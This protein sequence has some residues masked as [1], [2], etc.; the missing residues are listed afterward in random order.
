VICTIR[1]ER[2]RQLDAENAG[3]TVAHEEETVNR[4]E[5]DTVGGREII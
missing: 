5:P 4:S 2:G 3:E 1:T